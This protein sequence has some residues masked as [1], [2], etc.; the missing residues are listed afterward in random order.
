MMTKQRLK[1]NHIPQVG[2]PASFEYEVSNVKLRQLS[3]KEEPKAMTDIKWIP[4][5]PENLPESEVLAI[6]EEGIIKIGN[7]ERQRVGV[8][9][10]DHDDY[11]STQAYIP[12]DHLKQLWANQN[13]AANYSKD[14]EAFKLL[15]WV[16]DSDSSLGKALGEIPPE[17]GH[18]IDILA[19]QIVKLSWLVEDAP[20]DLS[21]DSDDFLQELIYWIKDY[22][23]N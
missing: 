12:V 17:A 19:N 11:I 18:T 5:D 20:R 1:V 13:P 16:I 10:F 4:V 21:R 23:A 7:L 2:Y 22:I 14:S 6:S 15:E 9:C 3:L 8:I